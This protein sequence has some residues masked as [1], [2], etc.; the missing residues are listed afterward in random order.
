LKNVFQR[1]TWTTLLFILFKDKYLRLIIY[2]NNSNFTININY[3][4]SS[5]KYIQ[6][7][8]E[9]GFCQPEPDFGQPKFAKR[10]RRT[11]SCWAVLLFGNKFHIMFANSSSTFGRKSVVRK[12]TRQSGA[13][14]S[15]IHAAF[16]WTLLQKTR[17]A[18]KW[19]G[20]FKFCKNVQAWFECYKCG[21][22]TNFNV[23][24]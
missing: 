7:R 17:G 14:L 4:I 20:F 15:E 5:N 18:W 12:C 1:I 19:A 9:M 23:I 2:K 10:Q 21:N 6:H 11:S 16:C 13:K 24:V 8:T 22:G 3:N